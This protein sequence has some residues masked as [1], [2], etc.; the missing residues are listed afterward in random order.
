[1]SEDKKVIFSMQ[2]L[3]LTVYLKEKDNPKNTRN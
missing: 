2:N 3:R 1:M